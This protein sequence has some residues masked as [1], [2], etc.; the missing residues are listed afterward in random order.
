MPHRLTLDGAYSISQLRRWIDVVIPL[1]SDSEI[2]TVAKVLLG[3]CPESLRLLKR[4]PPVRAR[5][6]SKLK[7]ATST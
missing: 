5:L 7:T 6:R 1:C 4:P 3:V 2:R